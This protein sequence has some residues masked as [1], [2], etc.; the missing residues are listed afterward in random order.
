MK[1]STIHLASSAF[2]FFNLI[3]CSS[4]DASINQNNLPEETPIETPENLGCS[5]VVIFNG[6]A[7]AACDNRLEIMSLTDNKRNT[8]PIPSNDITIDTSNQTLFVQA[9]NRIHALSIED[10]MTPTIIAS[11]DTNFGLFSGIAA[12]NGVIVVSGGT[13]NRNTQIFTFNTNELLLTTNGVADVDN[14]TGNPDVHVTETPTGITAFYS[15]DL[16]AVTNWGIRI[17]DFDTTGN[18][19]DTPSLVTLTSRRFTGGFTTI[20]PANFPVE[21]EFLNNKLYVAHFAINGIEVI[22]LENNNS[23]SQ[24]ILGYQPI[25]IT[26]D[27]TSLFVI[28]TTNKSISFINLETNEINTIPVENLQQPRGIAVSNNYIAIADRIEGLVIIKR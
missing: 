10:P 18:V 9:R 23:L 3:S 13:R 16:G 11:S 7:Y 28:G 25:N 24:I 22:D 8:V 20:S 2:I 26:T 4:D 15:Q 19:V 5:N 6:H 1:N 12:A 21:S 14:V 17:V 27:G